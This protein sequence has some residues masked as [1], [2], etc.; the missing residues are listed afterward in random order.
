MAK[1]KDK[2]QHKTNAVRIVEAAGIPYE[3][4]EYEAPEGFLDGVSVAKALGQEPGSVFKTLVTVAKSGEHYVFLM[5]VAEELDL[6]KAAAAVG[7]KAISMC[8][9]KDLL[10]LTGYI[11]GGCSPIGM[12]KLFRTTIHESA[13][14][15]P[16]I[17]C[18]AGKI[19]HQLELSLDSLQQVV[20]FQLAD[21]IAEK[22]Q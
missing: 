9:S 4:H 6:K 3:M 21:I 5:P 12:K 22:A 15:F 2:H 1:K 14:N 20:P 7:E 11:H 10:A 18:S 17:L 13:Q 16:T 19:G 8:K